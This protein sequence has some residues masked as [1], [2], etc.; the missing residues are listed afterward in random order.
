[1]EVNYWLG[2]PSLNPGRDFCI[3]IALI[4]LRDVWIYEQI[5]DFGGGIFNISM[6]T[7]VEERWFGLV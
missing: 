2:V 5:V 1:M 7:N 6:A 4:L 3:Y